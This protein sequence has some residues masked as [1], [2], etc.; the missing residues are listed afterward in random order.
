MMAATEK[1]HP[2]LRKRQPG[3]SWRVNPQMFHSEPEGP[4]VPTIP[5]G[6]INFSSGWFEQGHDV[7]SLACKVL[8]FGS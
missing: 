2:L 6:V 1:L 3:T 8:P 4:K 5:R 7:S